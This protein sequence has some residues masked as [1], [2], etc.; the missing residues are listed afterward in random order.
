M[1]AATVST[2]KAIVPALSSA[3]D[4]KNGSEP[5]AGDVKRVVE[6]QKETMMEEQKDAGADEPQ[7][8]PK[9]SPKLASNDEA[10]DSN[11]LSAA[12][13]SPTGGQG[14]KR[15]E[16]KAI[17]KKRKLS[18]QL[19][20]APPVV[21]ANGDDAF[22]SAASDLKKG[23]R[24]NF[25]LPD[26]GSS[27]AFAGRIVSSTNSGNGNE[28]TITFSASPATSSL[29]N[30]SQCAS[31]LKAKNEEGSANELSKLSQRSSKR[32]SMATLKTKEGLT[33]RFKDI[34]FHHSQCSGILWKKNQ[35]GIRGLRRWKQRYC[36]L[37]EDAF[38]YFGRPADLQPRGEIKFKYV[39]GIDR[40]ADANNNRFTI[41]AD[42]IKLYEFR[43]SSEKEC[44]KWVRWLMNV[45]SEERPLDRREW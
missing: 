22:S 9:P 25:T 15:G 4:T 3:V 29:P 16:D 10:A 38:Q 18:R 5:E 21:V 37:T 36:V 27:T 42:N 32:S 30:D 26:S 8:S 20:A 43:A 19:E 41:Y 23:D 7:P 17:A 6:E 39:T 33:M 35:E 11:A 28:F 45:F 24:I 2:E 13:A 14:H 12:K 44:D 40:I 34:G 1:S 31:T